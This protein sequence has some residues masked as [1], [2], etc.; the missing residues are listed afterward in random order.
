MEADFAGLTITE[1]DLNHNTTPV[2]KVCPSGID[3]TPPY[4]A[5]AEVRG[6]V[7]GVS[8]LS[9]ALYTLSSL[10]VVATTASG[11][12][13]LATTSVDDL[14]IRFRPL[15]A[16][17]MDT[18]TSQGSLSIEPGA[19]QPRRHSSSRI[20]HVME[21]WKQENPRDEPFNSVAYY[22]RQAPG[23]KKPSLK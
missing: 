23:V 21:Q 11:F 8:T 13:A 18:S 10:L 12:S 3:G 4:K 20:H 5:G 6:S 1:H 2:A 14:L 16:Q 15:M 22:A 17:C 7:S 19:E 9:L